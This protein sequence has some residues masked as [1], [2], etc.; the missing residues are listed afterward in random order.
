[1]G[2]WPDSYMH[3]P[4]I[5]KPIEEIWDDL[6]AYS[7][8]ER[9]E[10]AEDLHR[11][12]QFV[13][14]IPPVI[15]KGKFLKGLFYSQGTRIL[16]K[17]YPELKELFVVCANSMCFSYPWSEQADCYFTCYKNE[18][19][20]K[21]Y[22]NKYPNKSHIIMLPL[23]D[24]DFLN[25][26]QIAPTIN[27]PKTIDVFCVSTPFP[28]KNLPM[29]AKSLLAYEKR[30]GRRLKMVYAIGQRCTTKLSDGSLDYSKLSDYGKGPMREVDAIL[31]D[32]KQYIDF[33]PYIEYADLSRYYTASRVSVLGSLIEGKNRFIS[34]SMSCDTPIIVFKDFNKY[35]RGDY[36]VFFGNS[37][38]YAPE[39]TP[40]SL[41]DTIHKVITN[42]EAYEPRK[43]YLA[44][45]GRKN[46]ARVLA[47][48]IPYYRE[49]IPDYEPGKIMDNVWLDLACWDNY[50]LS[51]YDFLY[52]KKPALSHVI[53]L[54]NIENLLKFYYS[55]FKLE[56]KY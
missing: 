22:K 29:I 19:R 12:I 33:V 56:W 46:F 34:E 53:G 7:F 1:M 13:V 15:Y 6:D 54:E 44:H 51:Y 40:E 35:S 4:N 20:E 37:G 11:A 9:F 36:P 5:D 24:A 17:K 10:D 25:E 2:V 28:V 47:D 26:Y 16:L 52:G 48:S 30:Y 14:P 21:Y 39:F 3:N 42:P 55:R 49:N 41:A 32:T 43:N 38:E 31:G 27:T 45:N 18:A 23:Q 8:E 50:H